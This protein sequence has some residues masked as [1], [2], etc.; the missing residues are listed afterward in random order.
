MLPNELNARL[1]FQRWRNLS[2]ESLGETRIGD[3]ASVTGAHINSGYATEKTEAGVRAVGRDFPAPTPEQLQAVPLNEWTAH[4]DLYTWQGW[5]EHT[6]A[7]QGLPL[8]LPEPVSPRRANQSSS[9][10]GHTNSATTCI[11]RISGPPS[12]LL[13]VL[14][15]SGCGVLRPALRRKT[16]RRCNKHVTYSITIESSRSLVH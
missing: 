11:T 1:H 13:S 4:E 14:L 2:I 8:D 3:W 7:A 10:K 15:A 16:T 6:L 9:A 5:A 12:D